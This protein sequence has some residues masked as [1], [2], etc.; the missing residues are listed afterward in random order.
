[1]R[2]N[3]IIAVK[4]YRSFISWLRC[5]TIPVFAGG[6]ILFYS[7]GAWADEAL[8]RIKQDLTVG[9]NHDVQL[10]TDQ[11]VQV[12]KNSGQTVVI[13][14]QLPDGSNG[15]YQIDSAAIEIIAPNPAPPPPPSVV[16]TPA[17]TNA[18]PVNPVAPVPAAPKNPPTP[19]PAVTAVPSAPPTYP[20]DFVGGPEFNTTA[21]RQAAG[22]A[23]VIKLKDGTQSYIV[24]ARHLLGPDGGFKTQ[25]A[26]KDVP[27]FVQSIRIESFSGGS[28]HYDVT[29][30]LVPA[31]KLKADGG[32]PIDDMAIY[33]NHDATPQNQAV[34]LADQAPAVGT[35]VWVVARVRGGVPEG[36]IMQSAKVTSNSEWIIIQFDNDGIITAG[37][38]GAP[39]LNAAGE[40]IGVYSGHSKKDGHMLGFIIPAPLIAKII[41][42]AP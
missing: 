20:N 13:M 30:L 39:V 8:G 42:Q 17:A 11:V 31:T 25:T 35:P 15:V 21:G 41:K 24:S 22:T 5:G 7:V 14:V 18:G 1:M 23:S 36:Q 34:T 16:T 29:G 19:Q 27:A 2:R 40:V 38:S 10:K 28:Q 9:A 4:K 37:A 12:L 3:R 32:G 26:A 33:Q 6:A